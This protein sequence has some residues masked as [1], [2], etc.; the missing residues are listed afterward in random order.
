MPGTLT[1]LTILD[2]AIKKTFP[3]YILTE[4]FRVVSD[5]EKEK[6]KRLGRYQ[7][8]SLLNQNISWHFVLR[9]RV[10]IG[11]RGCGFKYVSNYRVK[12]TLGINDH[13]NEE[14]F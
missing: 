5:S 7:I 10:K 14:G 6:G 1:K 9:Y 8:D 2:N 12:Q 11:P 13:V 3:K 4:S